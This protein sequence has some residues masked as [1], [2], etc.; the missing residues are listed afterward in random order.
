MCAMKLFPHRPH[1]PPAFTLIELLVVIAI[2]GILAAMLLPTLASAK[3]KGARAKCISN[4]RQIGLSLSVYA[5]DNSDSMPV[6]T[7]WNGL[8]GQD[9][10]Y[11]GNFI[12]ATNRP[13]NALLGNPVVS[14]CPGDKGDPAP[15]DPTPPGINCWDAFGTSYLPQWQSYFGVK[16][17]FGAAG[18]PSIRESEIAISPSNKIIQGDWNWHPNRNK[19]DSRGI[20]HNFNGE[21]LT[22]IL[23]GDGHTS[24][25]SMPPQTPILGITPDPTKEW[26]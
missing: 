19:T 2:I 11:S 10:N 12:A 8:S 4:Q 26:W 22:V 17:V 25:F 1:R 3:K 6:I 7:F 15:W 23:W 16:A 21:S 13:L 5:T 9:G 24:A 14:K 18:V 20:W